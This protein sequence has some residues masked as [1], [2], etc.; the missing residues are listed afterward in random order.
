VLQWQRWYITVRST[1]I[2]IS[3]APSSPG[4]DAQLNASAQILQ[5]DFS[6]VP[7][8]ITISQATL[9]GLPNTS[10]VILEATNNIN[11]GPLTANQLTLLL[12]R[13]VAQLRL[14]RM[15]RTMVL[16]LFP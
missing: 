2:T 1:D 8:A 12:Y 3:N 9:E 14:E 16:A 11:I 10:T 6:P 7:G 15:L 5:N 4:V 13:A